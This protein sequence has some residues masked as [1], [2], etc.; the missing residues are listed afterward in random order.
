MTT[1]SDFHDFAAEVHPRLRRALIADR[2]VEGAADA[3]AEAMAYAWEHWN[4]VR[5]MEHPVGFLYRVGQSKT[6]VRKQAHLPAPEAVGVPDL[7][8][9]LVPALRSLSEQQ[10]TVIWLVHACEWTHAE[11]ADA[12]DISPSSVATH[13]ARALARLRSLLEV[14]CSA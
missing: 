5:L 7:E 3:A 4:R 13:A 2:G 10:R 8:P 12:L 9:K 11:V 1:P 6:R 14:D